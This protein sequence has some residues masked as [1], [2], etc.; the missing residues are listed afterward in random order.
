MIHIIDQDVS[1]EGGFL[2]ETKMVTR[3]KYLRSDSWLTPSDAI[4]MHDDSKVEVRRAYRLACPHCD[5]DL[6]PKIEETVY[7]KI[8][9]M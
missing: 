9:R 1:V 6:S 8:D 3:T 5:T 4:M 7:V 2:T